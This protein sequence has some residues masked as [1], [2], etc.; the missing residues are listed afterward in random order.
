MKHDG[1][2]NFIIWL[3]DETGDPI[4]LLVNEIGGFDGS[5]AVGIQEAGNYLLDVNADGQWNVTIELPRNVQGQSPPQQIEGHGH[6]VSPFL[7]LQDGLV[8]FEMTHDGDSNFIIWLLDDSGSRVDLL[9]NE[10]GQFDGS[11]ALG[12]DPGSYILDITA[13]GNWKIG[14]TQ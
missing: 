8:R 11:T 5:T 13:D 7:A 6:A 1:D 12:I 3:L 10:I 4:E 14:I 2:S 9:V